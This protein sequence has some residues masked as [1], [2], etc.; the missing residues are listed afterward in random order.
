[1]I[2]MLAACEEQK[3]KAKVSGIQDDPSCDLRCIKIKCLPRLNIIKFN[4]KIPVGMTTYIYEILFILYIVTRPII[5]NLA[6]NIIW[7]IYN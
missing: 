5:H 2:H 4:L 7:K 3:W 6:C 1:M